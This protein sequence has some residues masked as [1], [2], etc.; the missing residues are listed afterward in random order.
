[1]GISP[2]RMHTSLER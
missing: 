2:V 1:M